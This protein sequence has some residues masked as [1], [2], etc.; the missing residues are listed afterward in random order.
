[1]QRCIMAA[2]SAR[3]TRSSGRNRPSDPLTM[4]SRDAISMYTLCVSPKLPDTTKGRPPSSGSPQTGAVSSDGWGCA[5]SSS[6]GE[7]EPSAGRSG[8][9]TGCSASAAISRSS[10]VSAVSAGVS[11]SG[12]VVPGT[13][14]EPSPSAPESGGAAVS[15]ISASDTG[16]SDSDA[17]ASGSG[18]AVWSVAGGSSVSMGS[19]SLGAVCSS[20][21]CAGVS[22]TDCSVMPSC[23]V[24]SGIESC[25]SCATRSTVSRASSPRVIGRV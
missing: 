6:A 17:G 7:A 3:E 14:P 21:G 9:E 18:D 20:A 13:L 2:A 25:C 4:P 22:G 15:S 16:F 23:A 11:V 24:R 8:S 1:M 5:S 10:A 19:L 12:A